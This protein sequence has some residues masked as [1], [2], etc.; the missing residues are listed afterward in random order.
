MISLYLV[1]LCD[2]LNLEVIVNV[3][4]REIFKTN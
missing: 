2:M 1:P 3:F 4:K